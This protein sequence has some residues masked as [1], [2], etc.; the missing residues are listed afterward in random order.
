MLKNDQSP[1][2][3]LSKEADLAFYT[4]IQDLYNGHS[5]KENFKGYKLKILT[6]IIYEVLQVICHH[7][8]TF[9]LSFLHRHIFVFSNTFL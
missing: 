3:S 8:Q 2:D 1:P 4:N 9:I 7:P 6:E 5:I